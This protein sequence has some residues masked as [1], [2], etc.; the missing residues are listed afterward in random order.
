MAEKSFSFSLPER[1]LIASFWW[2]FFMAL[3][4]FV[5]FLR[6]WWW[7]FFPLILSLELNNVYFWWIRWDYNYASR[8]W[9]VL[10]I[11]PPKEVLVPLKA[12][13]DVFTVIWPALY[14]PPNFREKWCEGMLID[15]AEWMSFEIAS[16]EGKIHFYARVTEGHKHMV[17]S[18]LYAHYPQLEIREVPDYTK[19][20]PN[21]LPNEEWDIYGEDFI[22]GEES[23]YPIKTYEKFFEPQGERISAEEKRIDPMASLLESMSKLGAGEQFWLQFIIMDMDDNSKPLWKKEAES[24]IA[25]IAKRPVKKTNTLGDIL[26]ETVYNV[27]MGPKKEGSGDKA[28]YKWV[29]SAARSEEG[30]R[31]M[32]LTPGERELITEIENKMKKPIF[33]AS[34]RGFYVAKRESWQYSH[35]I[36]TRSYFSH[37][38]T[39]NLNYLRFSMVTR[40]KT[41]YFFRKRAPI[42]RSKRMLRNFTA[43]FTPLFPSRTRECAILSTEEMATLFHF[44]FKITG[45]AMPSTAKVESKKVG[46][47]TNLPME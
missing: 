46:P 15:G 32:V 34:I 7:I 24:I 8:K 2:L 16:I 14:S 18:A 12:M 39:K 41:K 36:L 20:I 38:Q 3:I 23:A 17:E 31:E 37:F 4:L 19:N 40:P 47:P 9:V 43:R 26:S 5:P 27:I 11:T 10:E 22:L 35:K 25:K 42:A 45:M 33:R 44:P 29:E 28:T 6:V 1:I 30:E 21:N 13:E